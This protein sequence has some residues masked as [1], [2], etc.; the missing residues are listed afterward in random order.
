MI[1]DVTRLHISPLSP[2]LL[3]AILGR[4]LQS[5]H[6]ISYHE[7]QTEP[8]KNYGYV[9]LPKMEA[10]N[11]KKKLNGATLKGKKIKI[12]DAKP[13][14]RKHEDLDP[15]SQADSHK[16]ESNAA[17]TKKSR[18]DKSK[19]L[20]G[21]ELSPDRKV[22]RG[23]T[24]GRKTKP[25]KKSDRKSERQKSKYT[26]KEELL[27]QTKVPPNMTDTLSDKQKKS[28]RKR[29]TNV[30]HEFEKTTLQPSFLKQDG[31]SN[32][33][34]LDYVDGQGWVDEKG[35]VVE[36]EP[37]NVKTKRKAKQDST[38]RKPAAPK[39]QPKSPSTGPIVEKKDDEPDASEASSSDAEEAE[40][41]SSSSAPSAPSSSD[42][43][44]DEGME[45]SDVHPLEALFKK[46][47]KPASS[48]D[49]AKPS[50]ELT[51]SNFSFFGG[52]ADDDIE[53][54]L[55]VPGTPRTSQD[56]RSRGL[57]SAAPTPDTAH[58]S[59]F[60]SYGSSGLQGD[61]DDEESDEEEAR[62]PSSSVQKTLSQSTG[63]AEPSDFEKMFWEKRGDNNRAWKARRRTVLKDNR[64]RE[65]RSRR[66][67]NW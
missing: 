64:Q 52:V 18:K 66:P 47:Q 30:I 42:Q 57:R 13:R 28:K 39:S 45:S 32:K 44:N 20:S 12:D 41:S 38:E 50:L 27:F 49:I 62:K 48:Q 26:D 29:D 21:H 65:N 55:S 22:K 17:R 36:P 35:N 5:A 7:I 9:D 37:Q 16:A 15:G 51:T 34:S 54:E 14:K 33:E 1:S 58:P 46:P 59:R 11:I 60:N 43:D 25:E 56:N 53:D 40:S 8:E 63:K 2:E 6:N 61:E 19:V 24:E 4:S 67:K 10:D 31:S 23:W 3:P